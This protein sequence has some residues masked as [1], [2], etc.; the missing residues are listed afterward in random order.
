[1][2]EIAPGI[3]IFDNPFGG[4]NVT[5]ITGDK[6]TIIV[7]SSL[8]PS[9]A[10]EIRLYVNRLLHSEVILVINTHYHP[11]HTFGNSGLNA[12]LLCCEKTEEYFMKMDSMYLESVFEKDGDLRSEKIHIVPPFET[13]KDSYEIT[14]DGC[15]IILQRVGGHTPDSVVVKIPEKRILISGDMV[16]NGFHPEIV[17]DSDIKE[18]I[19]VLKT[20]KREKYRNIICGHG[21]VAKDIE[22]D[23]MRQYLEK[24]QMIMENKDNIDEILSVLK[25]DPNFRDRHMTEIFL[26]SLKCL[27]VEA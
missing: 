5:A 1:V 21:A 7:D 10:E 4:S 3:V 20:L 18:W 17:K 12:N 24:M 23:R 11:D 27:M 13:F 6:G 16:I 25:E 15:K 2:K 19:K 9:K 26:E 22:I 14:H 8:Y